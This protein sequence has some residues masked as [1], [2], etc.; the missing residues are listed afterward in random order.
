MDKFW[1]KSI[2]RKLVKFLIRGF[3]I[4]AVIFLTLAFVG[5]SLMNEYFISSDFI[6]NSELDYIHDLQ[7]YVNKNQISATD[8]SRL[9]EWAHRKNIKHFT[10]SR[11]RA[12]IYDSTY[13]NSVILNNT[14]SEMLHYNWQYFHS[15][16]F[17]DGNADVFIYANYE[18]KYYLSF[19]ICNIMLCVAVWLIVF[20]LSTRNELKYIHYLSNSVTH[21]GQGDF[22]SKVTVK[23][24]DELST[25]AS[26]IDQ[27]RISLIEKDKKEA[28]LKDAQ[29]KLILGMTHDLRTP[30]TGL[31]TFLEIAQQQTS[32]K[33]CIKYTN[34]AY[35]KTVQIRDLSNQLFEFFLIHSE[36]PMKLEKPE[37]AEY[38]LGEYLSELCGLLAINGYSFNIENLSWHPVKI[39]I[40]TDYMGRIINNI[41]SNIIKYADSTIP[42]ELSSI[43]ENHYIHFTIKNRISMPVKHPNGTGIGVKNIHTMI[44]KMEGFCNVNI[45]NN[46]YIMTLTFPII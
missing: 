42:I 9:G 11:N 46:F 29:D 22:E 23:G 28:K 27:M 39:C 44:S 14:K 10:I 38:A 21:I 2:S 25:L 36:N 6:Y 31:M 26:G 33:E 34:K 24:C 4:A 40:N 7:E 3:L 19:Y 13:S 30:L 45:D 18:I 41:F 1:N 20:I 12:L 8:T 43:Y 17:A 16:S 15:V 37:Y 5:H 32:L 35:R